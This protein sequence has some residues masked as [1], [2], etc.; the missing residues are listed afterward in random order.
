VS[1]LAEFRAGL[2]PIHV[3]SLNALTLDEA[4]VLCPED[5]HLSLSFVIG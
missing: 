5:G 4:G 3:A 2:N 1:L